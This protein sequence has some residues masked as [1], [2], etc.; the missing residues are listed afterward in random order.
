MNK[1]EQNEPLEQPAVSGSSLVH[2]MIYVNGRFIKDV[3]NFAEFQDYYTKYALY[4][5][6]THE[7]V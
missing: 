4:G 3:Y 2:Y 1:D 6:I 7:K 5:K